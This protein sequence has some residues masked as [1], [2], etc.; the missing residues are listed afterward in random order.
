MQRAALFLTLT[1]TL[2][3]AC[4]DNRL[5]V[6]LKIGTGGM[7]VSPRVSGSVGNARLGLSG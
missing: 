3:T 5:G 7:S 6:G 1:L 4:T 2:L